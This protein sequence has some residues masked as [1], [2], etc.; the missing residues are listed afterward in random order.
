MDI[1]S[2]LRQIAEAEKIPASE[3]ALE[4]VA[5]L[6]DGSMRDALS[7]LDQCAAFEQENLT[8]AKVS[9]IVGI[10]DPKTLF[11]IVDAIADGDVQTAL[12]GADALFQKGKEIQNF[13]EELSTHLR[14]LLICKSTAQPELLLERSKEKVQKYQS[15]AEGFSAEQLIF[16]IK[17]L[18]EATAR[19]KWMTAPRLAAEMALIQLGNPKYSSENEALLARIEKLERMISGGVPAAAVQTAAQPSESAE[20]RKETKKETVPPPAAADAPPWQVD[21]KPPE[22]PAHADAAAVENQAAAA[23]RNADQ[24]AAGVTAETASAWGFWADALQEIKEE[25]KALFAFLYNAKAYQNGSVIE[26]ELNSQVAF[27]RI[28]TPKG[29][30]YLS[31]LFSRVCGSAVTVKAYMEGARPLPKEEKKEPET[32]ILDIAKK[33]ELF[34]DRMTVIQNEEE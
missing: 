10:A 9:E 6:G 17:V 7:I 30:S 24:G 21:E 16:M 31:E 34:G 2:R 27:S 1:A 25:S 22:K 5:E 18:G 12:L 4:L 32:G 28:A 19:A 20:K 23:E 3:D 15:Q 8:A 13:L 33:K 29:L 26:L 11:S 14:N